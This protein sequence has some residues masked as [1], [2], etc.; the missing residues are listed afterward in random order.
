VT[1]KHEARIVSKV[2]KALVAGPAGYSNLMRDTGL[3]TGD[4]AV[5]LKRLGAVHGDQPGTWRLPEEQ[6]R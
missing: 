1:D 2:R 5:A 3:K 4:I 6:G